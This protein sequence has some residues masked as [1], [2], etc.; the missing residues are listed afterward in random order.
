MMESSLKRYAPFAAALGL[1]GLLAAAIIWLLRREIDVAV[2]ASLAVGLLGLALA[3]LFNPAAVQTW[4]LGRQARYGGNVLVMV[5]ALLG[6]LVLANYLVYKNP[7]R[8][9]WSQDQ[10]NTLSQE[11]LNLL[12][13]LDQP[14]KA[15]GMDRLLRLDKPGFVGK[16]A[17]MSNSGQHPKLVSVLLTVANGTADALPFAIVHAGG[18]RVGFVTS[19]GYGHR[20]GRSLALAF[21]E[22]A[23]A[24]PG[25]P[26]EIDIFGERREAT[27]VDGAAYD[28][29]NSR[30]RV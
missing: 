5:L 20:I 19:A 30:V 17:V 2:Q 11:T 26:L 21:V 14:V 15:V 7:K 4:L 22:R 16:E 12:Q 25:T 27:V 8:W 1:V 3:L 9:D 6:I 28:P 29:D 10:T 18:A 24:A 13:T 23:M